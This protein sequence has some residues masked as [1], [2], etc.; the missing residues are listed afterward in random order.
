M[1][2]GGEEKSPSNFI[3]SAIDQQSIYREPGASPRDG[4]SVRASRYYNHCDSGLAW[5]GRSV[6]GTRPNKTRL[7]FLA[8]DLGVTRHRH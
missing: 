7:P 1:Q 3:A 6:P 2:L 8:A 4:I 5:R